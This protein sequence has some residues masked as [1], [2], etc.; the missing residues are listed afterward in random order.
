VRDIPINHKLKP[1]F[2]IFELSPTNT[3]SYKY[4][5]AINKEVQENQSEDLHHGFGKQKLRA[6][7]FAPTFEGQPVVGEISGRYRP[8][9]RCSF[10]RCQK[11][12][13]DILG[14]I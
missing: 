9:S 13:Q 10:L 6:S 7:D 2:L 11:S 8:L 5:V 14:N 1:C 4:S 12:W 3:E